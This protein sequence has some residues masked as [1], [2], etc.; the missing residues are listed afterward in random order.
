MGGTRPPHV[1]RSLFVPAALLV[2]SA[3]CYGWDLGL[4]KALPE[5]GLRT[6]R[7]R[8]AVLK[9]RTARPPSKCAKQLVHESKTLR[10]F[11]GGGLPIR[12]C[13]LRKL[14]TK[15]HAYRVGKDGTGTISCPAMTH[16]LRSGSATESQIPR[17]AGVRKNGARAT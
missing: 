17:F 13:R 10:I 5:L 8:H 16:A 7:N 14:P 15:M 1:Y 11:A 3:V 6:Y 2:L 4:S 9:L 12:L